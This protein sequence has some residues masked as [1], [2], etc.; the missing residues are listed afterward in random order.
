MKRGPL[1]EFQWGPEQTYGYQARSTYANPFQLSTESGRIYNF[2]RG[3]NFNPTFA[4]SEDGAKT[5]SA[6]THLIREDKQRPYVKYVSN[7]RDRIDFLFTDGHPRNEPTNNIYHMY[8]TGGNLYRSDGTLIRSLAE[9]K[10]G[11]P[12]LPSEATQVYD[13]RTE[14]RGWVW[15]LEY[16]QAGNPVAAYINSADGDLGKD[17]RYRYARWD[18]AAKHWRE[19]QIAYA[20]EHLYVPENHYAGGIS[21]DPNDAN[22]VYISTA[23]NPQT[24][25]PGDT[26]RRQIFRGHTADGGVMWKW[27]QLTFDAAADNLRPF[28]PRQTTLPT[29]VLWFRGQYT[30]YLNYDTDI[31]GIIEKKPVGRQ[32]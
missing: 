25:Q 7:G 14:G 28:V 5:W 16:D 13:G 20:G 3:L 31:V 32:R 2:F 11:H 26:G 29:C 6:A 22:T 15:D 1:T 4:T 19:Q 8:Y 9:V 24:G 21:I 23:V 18:A 27:E 30:T 12:V 10:S 17:L